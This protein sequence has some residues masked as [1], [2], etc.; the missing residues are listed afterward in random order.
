MSLIAD[1]KTL[2]IR[3]PKIHQKPFRIDK[4]F[5]KCSQLQS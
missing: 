2:Y 4:Y 1:G 3:D 5:I